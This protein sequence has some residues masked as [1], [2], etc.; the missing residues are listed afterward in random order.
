MKLTARGRI[1]L[2]KV[3]RTRPLNE[4]SGDEPYAQRMIRTEVVL[5]SD[6]V[7]GIKHTFLKSDGKVDHSDGWKVKAKLKPH[8]VKQFNVSDVEQRDRNRRTTAEAW[9][10]QYVGQGFARVMP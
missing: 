10:Q 6:G 3:S 5:L 7:V 8:V 9:T 2:A 1:I 4:P